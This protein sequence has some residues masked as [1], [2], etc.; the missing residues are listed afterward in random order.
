ML[1][2]IQGTQRKTGLHLT[3]YQ[4]FVVNFINPNNKFKRLLIKWETGAGKT[5]ADLSIAMNFIEFYRYNSKNMY[6]T[7]SVIIAGFTARVYQAELFRPEFG[8]ITQDEHRRLTYYQNKKEKTPDDLARLT[9]LV[10]AVKKRFSNRTGNGYF[11]FIGYR[12]LANRLFVMKDVT[13]AK[14][15]MRLQTMEDLEDAIENGKIVINTAYLKEFDGSLLICDEVHNTYNTVENNV[16]GLAIKYVLKYAKNLSAIVQ[17]ATPLNNSPSEI[18]NVLD[19]LNDDPL[20]K[21]GYKKA[22]LF[23]NKDE[24]KPGA[25]QKIEDAC[26]GKISFVRDV[27]P[28]AY[29]TKYIVGEVIKG[30]D[31]LKFIRTEMSPLHYRVY[32]Q[33]YRGVLPHD[34]QYLSDFILPNPKY[35]SGGHTKHDNHRASHDKQDSS[36]QDELEGIYQ[37]SK[38]REIAYADQKWKDKYSVNY[39]GDRIIG[40]IA[41]LDNLSTYSSKYA[42]MVKE[43]HKIMRSDMHGKVFIYHNSVI[44]S[45][46]LFI[47]E[48]LVRNGI[49]DEYSEPN[50]NTLCALCGQPMSN[51]SDKIGHTYYPARF[52]IFHSDVDAG[53][54]Q[55]S[56]DRFNSA[57]NTD[58]RYALILLGSEMVSESYNFMAT[59]HLLIM[60]RPDN[61]PM[62]KQIFGR[63]IR[64]N[65]HVLLPVEKRVVFIRIFTM[66]LPGSGGNKPLSY[67]EEKYRE[68]SHDYETIQKIEKIMHEVAIDASTNYDLVQSSMKPSSNVMTKLGTVKNATSPVHFELTDYKPEVMFK[69][70]KLSDL[71]VSKYN[72]YYYKTELD[73]IKMIIKLLF[74][75]TSPVW[76]RTHLLQAVKHAGTIPNWSAMIPI[77]TGLISEDL[78]ALA[79]DSLTWHSTGSTQDVYP[80]ALTSEF[81]ESSKF[82]TLQSDLPGSSSS[83]AAAKRVYVICDIQD[84]YV[85][86]PFETT[87]SLSLVSSGSSSGSVSSVDAGGDRSKAYGAMS[88]VESIEYETFYRTGTARAKYEIIDISRY[89]KNLGD[90]SDYKSLLEQFYTKWAGVQLGNLEKS[91]CQ[92][93][94]DFHVKLLE[95][96][97]GYVFSVWTRIDPKTGK[98]P[99]KSEYHD[100]YFKMLYFYSL[101]DLVVWAHT[102][103]DVL[104]TKYAKYVKP[105]SAEI[106]KT[107]KV[108][109]KSI[110]EADKTITTSGLLNMIKNSINNSILNMCTVEAQN[111]FKDALNK[112]LAAFDPRAKH[113]KVSADLLPVGHFLGEYPRFYLLETGWSNYPEYIEESKQYV[114]NDYIIGFDQR[115]KNSVNAK[116]KIRPPIQHIK[117]H[118]DIRKIEKGSIC[119][120]SKSKELLV[121][122]A[123]KL[124][125]DVSKSHNIEGL[126]S[127]IR[128]RLIYNELKERVKKTNVKWF[129]HSFEKMPD[130]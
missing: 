54:R 93:G 98:P 60:S 63:C 127:E 103:K 120:S 22:D 11:K 58:G 47:A 94:I 64:K 56:L 9:E 49:L 3:S 102:V 15:T 37:S 17:T 13:L 121:K 50:K 89:T 51:H 18:I 71:D 55:I 30:V 117:K 59:M 38:I 111:I 70:L 69:S 109:V 61:F 91:T 86:T 97:I 5:I 57:N 87:S 39:K 19:F 48:C 67:E 100:F 43:L 74:S 33:V 123:K 46:I 99:K 92:Y 23:T 95:D 107:Q 66:H 77:D 88:N 90:L 125:L 75:T 41:N 108:K 118:S 113:G 25:L 84:Y 44:M 85:L 1:E 72:I 34:S 35:H 12:A 62:L 21:E 40:E 124:G 105:V 119:S 52:V 78:F 128:M 6:D 110:S 129:Y 7:G 104:Y 68:K 10:G 14:Q 8:F 45:G 80:T 16:W 101:K 76:K 114:E 31:Y 65:S 27:N 73:L 116:F 20:H 26:R 126:C 106:I 82:I 28:D 32:K 53:K 112:S 83:G 81:S 79:L 24:L 36:M 130:F 2:V 96:C 122:V 42:G 29:P 4:Q 115:L